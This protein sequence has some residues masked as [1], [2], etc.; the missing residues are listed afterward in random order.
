MECYNSL[1]NNI[2]IYYKFIDDRLPDLEIYGDDGNTLLSLLPVSKRLNSSKEGV[3][4][5]NYYLIENG[6]LQI[7][8][9]VDVSI[10]NGYIVQKHLLDLNKYFQN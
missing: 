5:G 7:K 4:L 9:D 6:E 2:I 8:T 3:H 10:E 1:F